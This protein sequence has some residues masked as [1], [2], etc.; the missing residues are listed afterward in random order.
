MGFFQLGGF[1]GRCRSR[2][3]NSCVMLTCKE[4]NGSFSGMINYCCTGG[5]AV[6]AVKGLM[7]LVPC[8][9]LSVLMCILK[10]LTLA[11]HRCVLAPGLQAR[12]DAAG[13]SS[14]G[15]CW[16]ARGRSAFPLRALGRAGWGGTCER[17]KSSPAAPF[18]DSVLLRALSVSFL[19]TYV[20]PSRISLPLNIFCSGSHFVLNWKKKTSLGV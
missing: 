15:R 20:S 13:S 8:M 6:S 2:W 11:P 16:W 1:K 3:T 5:A 19:L 7:C 10:H 18:L 14:L 12:A 9:E 4:T 17:K